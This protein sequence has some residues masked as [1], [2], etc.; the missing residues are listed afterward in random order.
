MRMFGRHKLILRFRIL[1][2]G[3]FT[4]TRLC[5]YYNVWRLIDE[6]NE[7]ER[8]KVGLAVHIH[9]RV[10]GSVRNASEHQLNPHEPAQ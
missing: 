5:R 6:P 9:A 2:D 7:R 8:F 3:Q 4:G 10:R 1:V